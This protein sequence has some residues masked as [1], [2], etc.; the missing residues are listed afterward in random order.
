MKRTTTDT[1]TEQNPKDDKESTESDSEFNENY[2]ICLC[3]FYYRTEDN[4]FAENGDLKVFPSSDEKLVA[5]NA[6]CKR[7]GDDYYVCRK[8]TL[9]R[10]SIIDDMEKIRKEMDSEA[11]SSCEDGFE[12]ESEE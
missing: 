6:R 5:L 3:G 2:D 1:P 12:G 10:Q 9:H 4:Q 8:G 11:E 7:R